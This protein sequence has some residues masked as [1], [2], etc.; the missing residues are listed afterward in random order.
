[1][2]TVTLPSSERVIAKWLTDNY[3]GRVAKKT[4]AAFATVI[5]HTPRGRIEGFAWSS[6]SW[7]TSLNDSETKIEFSI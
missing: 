7:E 4:W 3:M 2:K 6:I 1:M 5:A